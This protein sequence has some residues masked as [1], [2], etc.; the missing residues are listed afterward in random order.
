MLLGFSQA[1]ELI[2]LSLSMMNR[3]S[4]ISSALPCPLQEQMKWW[5]HCDRGAADTLLHLIDHTVL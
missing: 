3:Y 1:L 5:F 4:H 2:M